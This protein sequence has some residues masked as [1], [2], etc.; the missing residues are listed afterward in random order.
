MI[1]QILGFISLALLL[2]GCDDLFHFTGDPNSRDQLRNPPTQFNSDCTCRFG[3]YINAHFFSQPAA[4]NSSLYGTNITVLNVSSCRT[5][6]CDGGVE[7]SGG[8]TK[9]NLQNYSHDT[10]FYYEW[11][12]SGPEQ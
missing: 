6:A 1:R 12:M 5:V 7:L 9:F 3:T 2:S 10:G 11:T 4:F 8:V